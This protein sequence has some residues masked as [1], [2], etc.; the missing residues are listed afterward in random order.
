MN[1][2]SEQPAR[3]HHQDGVDRHDRHGRVG[4][5]DR[6]EHQDRFDPQDRLDRYDHEG[7]QGRVDHQD[8]VSQQDRAGQQLGTSSDP[9]LPTGAP[10]TEDDGWSAH[11]SD[12]YGTYYFVNNKTGVSTWTNPRVPEASSYPG[13]SYATG[14]SALGAPPELGSSSYAMP[15]S[16]YG[17]PGTTSY[18]GVPGSSSSPPV[19][20]PAAGGYNP[21]I[22]GSWDDNAPYA[23][24]Y[25]DAQSSEAAAEFDIESARATAV[26][27]GVPYAATGAF[28]RFTGKFQAKADI[29]NNFTDEKKAGRQ[30]MEHFDVIQAANMHDGRSLKAERAA[31]PLGKKRVA[32]YKRR[33]ANRKHKNT[34]NFLTKE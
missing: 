12:E 17:A 25:R 16:T 34:M 14:I 15:S 2:E 18:Y 9:P 19:S 8:H 7:H 28:N 29:A 13:Y 3:N 27:N 22:H 5:H 32:F 33:E 20:Q 6:G 21:K 11:V 23:Q 10:A 1:S 24:R 4:R 30:M 26:A 31:Q